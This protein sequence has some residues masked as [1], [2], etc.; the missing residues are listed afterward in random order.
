MQRWHIADPSNPGRPAAVVRYPAAGTPNADV[1][2]VLARLGGQHTPVSWDRAAF[3]YLVTACWAD[4]GAAADP[5]LI[6]VQSRD[7]REMRILAVDRRT[8]RHDRACART[9][10]RTGWTSSR[11][12]PPGPAGGRIVWTAD[13]GGAHRLIVATADELSAGRAV[14][15]TPG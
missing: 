5:P 7:Q 11:A 15:V 8:G 10:T 1:S 9:P 13:S 12:C 14:P 2:L 6:V 3:P 4:Q